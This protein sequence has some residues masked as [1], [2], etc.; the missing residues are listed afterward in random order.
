MAIYANLDTDE[1]EQI[2]TNLGWGDFCRWADGLDTEQYGQ[3]AHLRQHGWSQQL[4]TLA[5]QLANALTSEQPPP[6]VLSVGHTLLR[7]VRDA[8]EAEVVSIS[9]GMGPDTET[10]E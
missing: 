5:K 9:D 1:Q 3:V 10:E 4:E 2:A 6:D 8:G 7:F